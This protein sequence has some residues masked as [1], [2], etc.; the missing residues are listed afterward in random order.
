[1]ARNLRNPENIYALSDMQV[2]V[3]DFDDPKIGKN[4][5]FPHYWEN[6]GIMGEDASVALK[7]TVD[8]DKVKGMGFGV[9]AVITKPG[10]VTAE[11]ESLEDNMTVRD[12]QWPEAQEDGGVRL[13]RNTGKP[14]KR[15]WA[16]VQERE[17]G[18]FKITVTREKATI[19]AEDLGRGA[20]PEGVKFSAEFFPDSDQVYFEEYIVAPDGKEMAVDLK[21]IRFVDDASTLENDPL[22]YKFTLGAP[23]GGT[24]DITSGGYTAKGLAHNA[25]GAAV[26]KALREAGDK[27]V[28]V[29][30]TAAAGFVVKKS[31]GAVSVNVLKLTGD[32]Y[33]NGKRVEVTTAAA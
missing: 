26:Q 5:F 7:K 15:H 25:D 28:E 16:W 18:T 1:M 19:T 29:T 6:V 22:V 20:K 23:T 32:K 14:A 4:G 8:K 24:W 2:Y 17:D 9:V 27:D 21:Q 31:N 12:L 11:F 13:L 30:G 3:T 33:P 10:E